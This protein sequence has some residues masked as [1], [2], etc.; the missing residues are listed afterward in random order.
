MANFLER[1]CNESQAFGLKNAKSPVFFS[2]LSANFAFFAALFCFWIVSTGF[3]IEASFAVLKIAD[4]KLTEKA[5]SAVLLVTP[6]T[7]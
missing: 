3:F 2:L 5:L 1:H 4:F 7:V 6:K